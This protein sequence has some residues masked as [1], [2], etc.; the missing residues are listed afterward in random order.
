MAGFGQKLRGDALL[1]DFGWDRIAG[2]ATAGMGARAP[3][4]RREFVELVRT[5]R[6]TARTKG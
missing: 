1:S 6:D 5:A 2:L 3:F 4:H